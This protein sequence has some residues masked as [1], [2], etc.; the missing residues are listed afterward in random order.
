MTL[1][2]AV[3]AF[4]EGSG[5]PL[6]LICT[7]PSVREACEKSAAAEVGS[8]KLSLGSDGSR[9]VIWQPSVPVRHCQKTDVMCSVAWWCNRPMPTGGEA[10]PT[11]LDLGAAGRLL[12]TH[13]PIV[14]VFHTLVELTLRRASIKDVNVLGKLPMLKR[15]DL[16]QAQV[17]DDGIIGLGESRS[18]VEVDLWGC[19][20]VTSAKTLGKVPTLRRLVLTETCVSDD[21]IAG[22]VDGLSI[23][24]VDL[25]ACTFVKSVGFF[26]RLPVLR[27]LLL[28]STSVDNNGIMELGSSMSLV[29]IDLWGCS[30]VD[31]VNSLGGIPTLQKLDLFGTSVTNEGIKGLRRCPSLEELDLTRCEAVSDVETLTKIPRLR[32]L[33]LLHTQVHDVLELVLMGVTVTI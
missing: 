15:L 3:L 26:G 9:R 22:L 29:E 7:S 21:G 25:E 16:V 11:R 27:R 13:L 6:A 4:Y 20:A 12:E 18:L 30:A 14:F 2:G 19:A 10:P 24:E 31:N 32:R 28:V 23:N 8:W 5:V 17:V 1:F 33:V